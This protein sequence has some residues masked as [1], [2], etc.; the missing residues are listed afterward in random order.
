MCLYIPFYVIALL[1]FNYKVQFFGFKGDAQNLSLRR[2]GRGGV[3]GWGDLPPSSSQMLTG[4]RPYNS[5]GGCFLS[6]LHVHVASIEFGFNLKD[7]HQ[8]I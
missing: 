6:H 7:L 4:M 1:S 2:V 3:G 5:G 8:I